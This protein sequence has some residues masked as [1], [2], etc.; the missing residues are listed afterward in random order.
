MG[1]VL[2]GP[3]VMTNPVPPRPFRL[4]RRGIQPRRVRRRD[5]A[6]SPPCE[7]AHASL[8]A[9]RNCG[10]CSSGAVARLVYVVR[11]QLVS[12]RRRR[13]RR[14]GWQAEASEERGSR[15]RGKTRLDHAR[16]RPAAGACEHVDRKDALEQLG[17]RHALRRAT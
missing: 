13:R 6:P 9:A 3:D 2:V 14:P 17:P 1:E 16:A 12:S 10:R 8:P 4:D 7:R 11:P 15:A 5:A